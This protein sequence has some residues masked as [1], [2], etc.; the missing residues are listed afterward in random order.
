MPFLLSPESKSSAKLSVSLFF[1]Q[2]PAKTQTE[3]TPKLKKL[4]AQKELLDYEIK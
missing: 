2:G 4:I 3:L 1:Y